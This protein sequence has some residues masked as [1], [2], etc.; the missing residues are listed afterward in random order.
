MGR[1]LAATDRL[2]GRRV[3]IKVALSND[4]VTQQRLGREAAILSSLAHDS[5]PPIYELGTL[6]GGLAYFVTR[7]VDGETL[8]QRVKTAPGPR[9]QLHRAGQLDVRAEA[10]ARDEDPVLVAGHRLGEIDRPGQLAR[11]GRA[12]DLDRA[13][14]G[15]LRA[16]GGES[17]AEVGL[18]VAARGL[19]VRGRGNDEARLGG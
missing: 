11:Q 12:V 6:P 18:R 3:A 7:L 14:L 9:V 15:G 16:L 8:E 1:V 17:R 19:A 10:V 5:L 13:D 4:P 2:L